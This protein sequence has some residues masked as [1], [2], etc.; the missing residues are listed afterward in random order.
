MNLNLKFSMTEFYELDS[1]WLNNTSWSSSI[2]S[3][4]AICKVN[5][6]IAEHVSHSEI[7]TKAGLEPAAHKFR[8]CSPTYYSRMMS[9][10]SVCCNRQ[11]TDW[12]YLESADKNTTS[13]HVTQSLDHVRISL[14]SSM[15]LK[16]C[17]PKGS[18]VAHHH[19]LLILLSA[20]K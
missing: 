3:H 18:H 2:F 7:L 14:P 13:G 16:P 1:V 20:I 11:L 10:S 15:S 5:W 19:P 12:W 6:K 8:T 4:E 9:V 17:K